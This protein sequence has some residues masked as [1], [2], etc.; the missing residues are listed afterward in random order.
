MKLT[1]FVE[2]LCERGVNAP[3][4]EPNPDVIVWV[5][6]ESGPRAF[7]IEEV[8]SDQKGRIVVLAPAEVER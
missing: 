7:E 6:A 8:L 2:A 3:L 5:N 1:E 4:D